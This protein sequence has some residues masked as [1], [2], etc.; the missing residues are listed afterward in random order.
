[1]DLS[2]DFVSHVLYRIQIRTEGRP[3]HDSDVVLLE[4]VPEMLCMGAGSALLE[5]DSDDG[6]NRAQCE[7]EGLDWY[8]A[9][10]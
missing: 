1:M 9:E 2:L 8:K 4:K 6:Q 5:R 10:Q 3:W 7:V